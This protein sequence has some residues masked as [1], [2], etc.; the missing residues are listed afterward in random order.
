MI[1][2]YESALRAAGEELNGDQPFHTAVLF[3]DDGV[4][5][6]VY[7]RRWRLILI[8]LLQ[9]A[10]LTGIGVA[11]AFIRV[12]ELQ[13]WLLWGLLGMLAGLLLAAFLATLTRLAIRCP[14]LVVGPDGLFDG[15]SLIASGV[16]LLRWDEILAAFPATRTSSWVTYHYLVHN[17]ATLSGIERCGSW[18]QPR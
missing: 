14:S 18:E 4:R 12:D 2:R 3:R 13:Q 16:G 10:L 7:P 6:T 9:T 15:G 1:W 8:A 11:F 17:H 5:I